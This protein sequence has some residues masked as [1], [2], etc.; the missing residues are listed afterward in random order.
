MRMK[1]LFA[2]CLLAALLF[3]GMVT[4][5][6]EVVSFR[7]SYGGSVDDITMD[8]YVDSNGIYTVGFTTSFGPNTP[9]AFLTIF[10]SDNSHRCSV[11]LDLGASD[12][13]RALTFHNNKIYML[14]KTTAGSTVPNHFVAVFDTSC[15]LQAIKLYDI[16][17]GEEPTDIDV[18]PAA[19]PSFYVVGYQPGIGGFVEKLDSSLN[20]VWA[21]NFKVRDVTDVANAVTFSG[22]RIWF[23]GCGWNNLHG[24]L[25][26]GIWDP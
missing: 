25:H 16:G 17:P 7:R 21:K 26:G 22:G 19:S 24:R 15:N 9:N 20:M 5:A 4:V 23:N 14:G 2:S 18:E 6:A 8:I 12:E 1:T 3:A 11:A 10:N 13:A